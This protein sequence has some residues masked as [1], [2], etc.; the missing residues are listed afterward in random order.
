[1]GPLLFV[2]FVALAAFVVLNM[3]IAIITSSYQQCTAE[4]A[5]AAA[6]AGGAGHGVDL[7]R[8]VGEF[9]AAGLARAPGPAGV[10]FRR[11][12]RR[13]LRRVRVRR[14]AALRGESA[15]GPPELMLQAAGI[16]T[17]KVAA[18]TAAAAAAPASPAGGAAAARAPSSPAANTAPAPAVAAAASAAGICVARACSTCGKACASCGGGGGDGDDDKAALDAHAQSNLVLLEWYDSLKQNE[19]ELENLQAQLKLVRDDVSSMRDEFDG[20]LEKM[21]ELMRADDTQ[22]TAHVGWEEEQLRQQERQQEQ[23]QQQL[24]LEQQQ[25]GGE[26]GQLLLEGGEQPEQ[27]EAAV[28]AAADASAGADILTLEEYAPDNA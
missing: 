1:M 28:A 27:E 24:E 7:G 11:C 13:R 10:F 2:L 22:R 6:A 25:Q 16:M 18:A 12:C 20:A 8:E 5:A 15:D 4:R 26:G 23:Q 21:I 3:L 19:A 14:E 9:L 17:A